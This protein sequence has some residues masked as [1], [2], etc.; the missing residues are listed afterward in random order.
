MVLKCQVQTHFSHCNFIS[1]LIWFYHKIKIL[2]TSGAKKGRRRWYELVLLQSAQIR[3][4][5]I[6]AKKSLVCLLYCLRPQQ[7]HGQLQSDRPLFSLTTIKFHRCHLPCSLAGVRFPSVMFMQITRRV[8]NVVS[9]CR[10][11]DMTGNSQPM[12]ICWYSENKLSFESSKLKRIGQEEFSCV[13]DTIKD[14]KILPNRYKRFH[15]VSQRALPCIKWRQ[16]F[17]FIEVW[18]YLLF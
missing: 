2:C 6:R 10:S 9:S 3:F 16:S 8:F 4:Y 11:P 15:P 18:F 14:W 7:P 1:Y 5:T 17:I 12:P 13:N